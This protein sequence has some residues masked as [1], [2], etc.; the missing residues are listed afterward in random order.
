MKLQNLS[1]IFLVIAIPLILILSYY[2][3]LQQDTLELQ[4][5][6]DLKL[7]EAT[8]EGIKAFEVNTVDWTEWTNNQTNVT[9]R[10]NAMATI[11]T[12]LTSL[13]NNLNI[14]GTAKEYITNYIPASAVTMY[15]GYYVYA[16]T[17]VPIPWETPEGVQLYYDE[18][19]DILTDDSE[20]GANLPAYK[21]GATATDFKE[22]VYKY[23]NSAGTVITTTYTVKFVTDIEQAETE[24]KHML[25]NQIAYSARYSKTHP[26]TNV[27]VNYT[28]DNR[29]YVYGTINGD[30]IEKDGYLVY[31]DGTANLPRIELK[32]YDPKNED[33]IHVIKGINNSIYGNTVI[34]AEIL[35][36]QVLYYDE[37]EDKYKLETFKYIYDIEDEK[38]YYDEDVT[39]ENFFQIK[40]SDKT[41]EYM[42]N[43]PDIKI[44]TVGCK[45]KSVSV[46]WGNDTDTTEYK[47]IYQILNGK[48]KGKWCI[49][50]QDDPVD[51]KNAGIEE[52]DTELKDR[53]ADL[54]L[55]QANFTEI[56]RDYSAISYYVEAYAFTNWARQNLSGVKQEIYSEA[57]NKYE[58]TDIKVEGTA[59]D[60]FNI[61]QNNDPEMPYSPIV[62]HKKQIMKDHITTNLNLSIS[63]YGRG[64]YQFKMPVLTDSDWE[65]VFSNI[66]LITFFQGIPI[67]LKYYNN[68]AIATSNTNRE[69][70]DPGE[71]Y[72][73]GADN[74][75]HRVYCEKCG[76]I[77]YT[78]YRSVEYTLREYVK[79][80]YSGNITEGPIYYYQHDKYNDGDDSETACYYCL[81]N[82][83]NFTYTTNDTIAYIQT[84]AYNEALARERYYQKE[85]LTGKLVEDITIYVRRKSLAVTNTDIVF[86][87]DD[88]SSMTSDFTAVEN[89]AC[90]IFTLDL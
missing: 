27:I 73:T 68:Y 65:Q 48:D 38:W 30:Y 88:S 28:L 7:A 67:G 86:I 22:R 85:K 13:S 32:T 50:I 3:N 16:P 29:I 2:L 77:T 1:I 89:S 82:K 44:D 25:S 69:Y 66:S 60:I 37:D 31:F 39:V 9:R 51:L 61:T 34:E 72:F 15:D 63:N 43:E 8:K 83:E 21:A 71:L 45:F 55:D 41:R 36:E 33:D 70:V 54:G 64:T 79:H 18:A 62:L 23:T 74:T 59:A 57:D 84:K 40:K 90:V 87:L 47:K 5:Q 14:S 49:S 46:L 24:Y 26:A 53:I 20:N 12:F 4:A 19:D 78:G 11:N 75:Y 42:R 52:I 6:Y 80:D 81:V 56:Y 17:Y 58:P 35:E 10:N 76:N